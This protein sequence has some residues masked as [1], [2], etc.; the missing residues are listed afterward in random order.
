MRP[1]LPARATDVEPYEAARPDRDGPLLRVNFVV[2]AD[3]AATDE[4]GRSGGLGGPG[5]KAMF[6]ALRAH[7]DGI[8]VG[9]GTARDEG[10]GPHRLAVDLAER[11]AADGRGQPAAIVLVSRSLTLDLDAEVFTAARTPTIVV[12]C[13]AAPPERRA[14]VERAGVLLVAGGDQVDLPLAVRLLRER[15]GLA[16]LLC[17]GGPRLA[18]GVLGAGLAD[19]LCLTLAPTVIGQAG[20]RMLTGLPARVPLALA[21]AHEQDGELYLRYRVD[22]AR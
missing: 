2:S 6:R 20:P 1:L 19:E 21:A 8:V 11:R 15:H 14:A 10:Y 17:E 5:D 12:T 18:S 4:Q 22:A 16:S 7:A 9:A 13:A 3:G